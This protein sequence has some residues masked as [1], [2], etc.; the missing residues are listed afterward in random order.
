M[1][2]AP[3][4]DVP[5]ERN[6]FFTADVDQESIAELTRSIIE[7]NEHDEM[8]AGAYGIYNIKYVPDPIKIYIDSYGGY[9]YQGLG[10]ISV[11]ET[12]KTPV[13]TIATGVAMSCG[14]L[15]LIAGHKRFA[16]PYST[17]MYHQGGGEI[18]GK[19]KD[20]EETLS[21]WKKLE[22]MCNRIVLKKTKITKE[23]LTA[24]YHAKTDTY[25]T[26][27]QALKLKVIDE[28]IK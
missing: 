19:M 10:A 15:I 12:S 21:Q 16:Y 26:A 28:I 4:L 20:I 14:F 9:I 3:K 5:M 23:M 18:G 24:N 8:I 6:L 25:L 11:I 2:K 1:S 13:H 7:I 17:M 22:D 27:E